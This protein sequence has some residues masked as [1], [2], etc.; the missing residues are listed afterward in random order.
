MKSRVN[1]YLAVLLAIAVLIS[2]TVV[3]AFAA[4]D[5]QTKKASFALSTAFSAENGTAKIL[6]DVEE[7]S[8]IAA[9]MFRVSFD[10]S[11]LKAENINLGLILK[12]GT[13]STN[14]TKN[15]NALI[16]YV[17]TTP[18]YDGGRMFEI[19]FSTIGTLPDNI[20]FED[21]PVNLEVL[22][23]KDYDDNDI[24]YSV[25]QGKI[26]LINT[27]YGDINSSDD[28][29]ATD[30]LMTL[31]AASKLVDL[32]T[33]QKVCADVN[34][35]NKISPLD[36]LLILQFS[37]G[38]I[39]NFPI[40]NLTPPE[41]L[42]IDEKDET[43]VT[44]AWDDMS[45][46]IGYNVYMNGKKINTDLVTDNLYVIDNLTQDTKY[47]F[48]VKSVNTLKESDTSTDLLVSTN[49]ADRTVVF[50]DY[51]GSV[52]NTQIV[53]SGLDA[54]EPAEPYRK[55]YTFTGWNRSLKNITE[56]TIITAQYDIN[57]YSVTFD[58]LYNS[59]TSESE[60]VYNTLVSTPA[61]PERTDY[62]FEGWYQDRT[63]TKKWNFD[64]D[65]IQDNMTLYAN[66]VT[67]S[68]WSTSL[69]TNITDE[70]YI[71]ES[72]TETRYRTKS[73]TSS[74]ASSLSGW[75]KYDTQRTSWGATQGPVYSNPSN[76]SRNV[77]S[78]NYVSSTTT[79]YKYYHR[80]GW[81][82]NVSTGTNG[83]VW[84]SDSQLGSGARHE[85]DL[86]WALPQ[87]SNFAG[88]AC[89]KGYTCPH[90]GAT[91]I[92]LGQSSYSVNNYSTRWYYQEPVYTYYYY[93]WSDWSDW[94]ATSTEAS[95]S[96]EVQTRTT[97]RYLLRGE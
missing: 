74:S 86:T 9:A 79:H 65:T 37:A 71:I 30:S 3:Q 32:T 85:I 64:S 61:I 29:T 23:L 95:D 38:T 18:I 93:Q 20:L 87:T 47:N 88:N 63:F 50:K 16:A 70:N 12:N 68:S 90:C 81:G 72:R 1:K 43:Y 53:L 92:W 39:S 34:G 13:T 59:Q 84:G 41:N 97:Y 55:G 75:T 45:A 17:N 26:T 42:R 15:G 83:Y 67:W 7:N 52:I 69:P 4:T 76:G 73:T 51:D 35:D 96:K 27:L 89:W 58:Y 91:N 22:D 82:Y 36:A 46:V 77:W 62:T 28:V 2:S 66:W 57:T 6:V 14:I 40:F 94:S 60:H 33:E 48:S 10:T 25:T 44:L 8:N 54:V 80:Y 19:E 31:Y 24:L 78:E 21:I 5:S 49:K 56:D 11:K